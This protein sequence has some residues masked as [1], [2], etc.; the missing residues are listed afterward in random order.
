MVSRMG[1]NTGWTRRNSS[2]AARVLAL[3]MA[4]SLFP[5]CVRLVGPMDNPFAVQIEP[6]SGP[7]TTSL[8]V[9]F[10]QDY[11]WTSAGPGAIYHLQVSSSVEFDEPESVQRFRHRRNDGQPA[12]AGRQR[13]LLEGAVQ[14]AR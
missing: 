6:L 1:T 2:R 13:Q 4:A 10:D 9:E 8:V 3:M 12:R 14:P 11:S 7:L 5:G